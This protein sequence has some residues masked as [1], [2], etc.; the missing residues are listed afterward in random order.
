MTTAENDRPGAPLERDDPESIGPYRLLRRLG[1]GGMGVAY[2]AG[3]RDESLVVVKM[4]HEHLAAR[5]EFRMR[6]T[7][8]S[9]IAWRLRSPYT[10]ALVAAE[11]GTRPYLVTEYV[12][13]PTLA[14]EIERHGPLPAPHLRRLAVDL[15]RGLADLHRAGIVHR[16]IKPS[17]IILS[18]SGA[19]VIDLGLARCLDDQVEVTRG[20]RQPGTPQLMA[21]EQWTSRTPN[22]ATDIFAWGC[23]VT[24]AGT[25]RW[26]FPG[27]TERELR[28]A[29]LREPPDLH[30]LDQ[31]L[32]DLV[33]Q[34]L[35]KVPDDRPS[36]AESLGSLIRP[37]AVS[38][39]TYAVGAI[40]LLIVVVAQI[41]LWGLLAFP[42]P[43]PAY[44]PP[45]VAISALWLLLSIYSRIAASTRAGHASPGAD[46]WWETHLRTPALLQP[47]LCAVA[48][49][50]IAGLV[51]G[52]WYGLT[53]ALVLGAAADRRICARGRLPVK[54]GPVP[55][56]WTRRGIGFG[57]T[58][59]GGLALAVLSGHVIA[60]VVVGVCG[61][62]AAAWWSVLAPSLT[63]PDTRPSLR[64]DAVVSSAGAALLLALSGNATGALTFMSALL[65]TGFDGLFLRN[66]PGSGE[67]YSQFTGMVREAWPAVGVEL[68][69]WY[70]LTCAAARFLMARLWLMTRSAERPPAAVPARS[71]R[72]QSVLYAVLILSMSVPF[73]AGSLSPVDACDGY[74]GRRQRAIELGNDAGVL[75]EGARTTI[76]SPRGEATVILRWTAEP[77]CAWAL[78]TGPRIPAEVWLDRTRTQR[79]GV[80]DVLGISHTG[81]YLIDPGHIRACGEIAGHV[82]CTAWFPA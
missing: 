45:L 43:A 53:T 33:A 18:A 12:P 49:G 51:S 73:L 10:P 27:G 81:A 74:L 22:A 39:A 82:G 4:I 2:L 72:V 80:R 54:L 7:R 71:R 29:I 44:V 5:P 41:V 25:G 48:T 14:Q 23:V 8:E 62:G 21:P 15:L 66:T 67:L 13:G 52:W 69:L 46:R 17:N 37:K 26:P 35:S 42:S 64:R 30:G 9:V 32:R 75:R 65:M 47:L 79:L 77:R 59:A 60:G 20:E 58:A 78:M 3:A 55:R 34:S 63:T 36:A 56:G 76:I 50:L 57:L 24:F 61:A 31:E 28:H 68:G 11:T 40:G 6:F 16:D 19:R 38:R 1:A 70:L